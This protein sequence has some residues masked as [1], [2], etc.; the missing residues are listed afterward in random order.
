MLQ[1]LSELINERIMDTTNE[2]SI[3]DLLK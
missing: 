3:E 2:I 1:A